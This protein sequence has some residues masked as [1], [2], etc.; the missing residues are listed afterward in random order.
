M[1]ILGS[2]ILCTLSNLAFAGD[3]GTQS[4]D[5]WRRQGEIDRMQN[6]QR[7]H[8]EQQQ[9]QMQELERRQRQLEYDQQRERMLRS[10]Q[11]RQNSP[12]DSM[13]R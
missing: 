6:Q 7:I 8:Q 9:R 10:G 3:Y 13:Y 1:K 4:I 12:A 5:D 11:G 2:I